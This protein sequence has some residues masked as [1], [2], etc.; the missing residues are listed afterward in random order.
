MKL[1]LQNAAALVACLGLAL[2]VA[3]TLAI[4]TALAALVSWSNWTR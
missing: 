3:P 4:I 1:R 2:L